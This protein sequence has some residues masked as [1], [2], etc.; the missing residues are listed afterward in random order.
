MKKENRFRYYREKS[1]NAIPMQEIEKKDANL[2]STEYKI[3]YCFFFIERQ[4]IIKIK[5][6]QKV[7]CIFPN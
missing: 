6:Y 7:C 1:Q 2:N 5:F 3:K 4:K